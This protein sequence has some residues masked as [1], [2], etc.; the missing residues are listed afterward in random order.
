MSEFKVEV[1][2]GFEATHVLHI[3]AT[4]K[5]QAEYAAFDKSTDGGLTVTGV[6]TTD[7]RLD[8]QWVPV[9]EREGAFA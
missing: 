3:N 1:E 7:I 9:Y 5:Q 6:R 8:G 2:T 4:T